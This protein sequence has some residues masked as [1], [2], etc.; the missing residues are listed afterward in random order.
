MKKHYIIPVFIPEAA[1]PNKCIYCNQGKITGF[2]EIPNP[3]YISQFISKRLKQIPA[4][5]TDIQ[6]A[7]FGGNFTGLAFEEQRKMLMVASEF[8]DGRRVT[9]IRISTRPDYIDTEKLSLLKEFPVKNIELGV[10]SMFDDVLQLSA[11]GHTVED[12]VKASGLIIQNGFHLGLQIMAGLPGDTP[13]KLIKTAERI[14]QLG[15]EETRIY[16]LLVFKE[17][18]LYELYLQG[19]YKPLSVNETIEQLAPAVLLFENAGVKILR[20]G[21]HPSEDLLHGEMVAGPWHPAMRQMIYTH[22][23]NSVLAE[24]SGKHVRIRVS[25]EQF[26]NATGF[27]RKNSIQFPEIQFQADQ[28]LKGMKHEV[29]YC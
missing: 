6:I 29:D 27:H 12:S 4:D 23:W 1:C 28:S 25:T 24:Y 17:T 20:I 7:F 18:P 9:S 14:I 5:V 2:F 19:K 26:P 13:E 22:A 10:Q 16:P 21:L 8:T 15:A 3:E 11:R